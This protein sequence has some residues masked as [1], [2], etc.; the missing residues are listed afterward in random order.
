MSTTFFSSPSKRTP[1]RH[2]GRVAVWAL[3]IAALVLLTL[4]AGLRADAREH[5]ARASRTENFVASGNLKSLAVENVNGS[6]EILSGAPFRADV[7]VTAYASTEAIAKKRL[8]D[9]TVR[10]ENDKGELS[11]YTEEPGVSVRRSRRGW[12]VHSDLDDHTWRT[13]VKYRITAPPGLSLNVSTVNGAVSVLDVAAPMDLSTVNGKID[14]TRARREAK[15]ATVNGAIRATFAELQKGVSVDVRTVNGGIEL[16][17]PAKAGFRF[18]GH[19]MSGEILSSFALPAA[20]DDDEA[21]RAR[22]EARA[23]RDRARAD[24]DKLKAEIREKKHKAR[25]SEEGDDGVIDLSELNEALSDLNRDMAEMSRELS[26]TITIRMNR[27]YEGTVGG[28][29]ANVKCSNL[30]GRIVL[31]AEGTTEAQAKKL[32]SSRGP[33]VTAVPAP[34]PRAPVPPVPPA[35]HAAPAPAPPIPPM[36][37]D[38]WGRAI[39]KGDL[40]GDL[41]LSYAPSDVTAGVIGG[42]VKISTQSGQIRVKGAGKGAELS[43]AGGDIRIESVTGD[44]KATTSGGDIRAG[45]VSGDARLETAGGDVVVRSAGGSVAARTGGGDITL[46]KV[47]GPVLARTSGG[48][49]TCEISSAGAP[50]GELVTSGGDV[51]VTLPSNYRADIDARVSGAE[52]EADAISS[53]FPEVVVTRRPGSISGEGKLN[54]GGPKLIIRS[55]SGSVSIRRGPAA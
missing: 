55:T 42:R 45:A 12:N 7:D 38:P 30:N 53:Q 40:A 35:P 16:T 9:V 5:S 46:K 3:L 52:M 4:A 36:P 24:R 27:A 54:G 6:V 11:L 26:R 39:S 50:G 21:A 34:D 14:V 43:T 32:T 29:G 25:K 19:T 1:T 13:E 49:I 44:L 41:V 47:H 48:T 10:F 17:L 20:A 2:T 18:Q 33:I 51:T 8:G 31:L 15:L 37:V 22:D 23:A 28:G